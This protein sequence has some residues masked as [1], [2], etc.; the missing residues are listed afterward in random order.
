MEVWAKPLDKGAYAIGFFNRGTE[1]ADIAVN[2]S[3]VGLNG[4]LMV[5][6][7]WAH[8]GRGAIADRFTAKVPAHGVVMIRVA[9]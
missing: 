5:R 1:A 9:R 6:D 7:L 3:D 4:K 2:W 8:A